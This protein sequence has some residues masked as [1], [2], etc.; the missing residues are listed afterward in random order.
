M[1]AAI[2]PFRDL[3]VSAEP[4]PAARRAARRLY[5]ERCRDMATG[6]V[7]AALSESC[8]GIAD[9]GVDDALPIFV[10]AMRRELRRSGLF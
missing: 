6:L 2:L 5:R 3:G 8:K 7:G 10:A 9:L 4:S 1:T